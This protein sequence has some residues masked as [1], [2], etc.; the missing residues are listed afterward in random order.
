MPPLTARS[1]RSL[2]LTA[3]LFALTVGAYFPLWAARVSGELRR[4]GTGAQVPAPGATALLAVVPVLN[5]GGLAYL[6]VAL[7]RAIRRAEEGAREA[8]TE[9]ISALMIAA[10]AG[11]VA[12]ALLIDVS[13][14]LG[15]YLAWPLELPGAL[16]VQRHLNRLAA[17]RP[18]AGGRRDRETVV[19]I[20]LAAVVL[21]T[22]GIALAFSGED[23]DSPSSG[24]PLA[25][26]S[27][28][29]V[30]S[31][32]AVSP[33]AAWWTQLE[34][35]SVQ[36]LAKG[37]LEPLGPPIKVGREPL[38]VVYGFGSVW[39]ANRTSSTVTR[40]DPASGRVIGRPFGV[41]RAPWGLAIGDGKVW[42]ANQVERTASSID[43][44]SGRVKL[45]AGAAGI[46]PRGIAV[47]EGAVWV[48]N[49]EGRS[50]SRIDPDTG[51]SRQIE[52]GGSSQDVAA[53]YGSVWVTRPNEGQVSVLRP[54]GR[55]RGAPIKV[56]SAPS[57][58]TAGFG[59]IWVANSSSGTVVR[60]DPRTRRV[61]GRPLAFDQ[62]IS[63]IT[64]A[65]RRLWVLQGDGRV[66]RT[67]VAPR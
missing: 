9:I 23:D 47:G 42:V 67:K 41:G 17:E 8:N 6:A 15:G 22:G 30:A 62:G 11:G 7:P 12:L 44:Q 34:D 10:V 25:A 50:V 33:Q 32:L 38:G 37:T 54:D 48:A 52:I 49:F 45:K 63:D 57:S 27:A 2:G 65:D 1:P 64:I 28:R 18:A 19:A 14:L 29:P 53:A 13:P 56:G 61:T 16:L 20:G 5:I 36:R 24:G 51:A 40:I 60:I 43:P 46:G 58:I 31:D 3:G 39:V 26:R 66:R 4:F 55:R 59:Q 35:D 21:A